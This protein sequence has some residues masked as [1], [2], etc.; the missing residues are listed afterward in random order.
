MRERDIDE[1]NGL[2]VIIHHS[3]NALYRKDQKTIRYTYIVY[4][5]LLHAYDV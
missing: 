4:T 5:L 2:D 3:R 1:I